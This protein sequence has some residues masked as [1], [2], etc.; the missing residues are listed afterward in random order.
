MT[1]AI[2][3]VIA[4]DW[5]DVQE[6]LFFDSWRPEPLNRYRTRYCFRGLSDKTYPLTTTLQRLGGNFCRVEQFLLRNFQKYAPPKLVEGDTL[7]HWL[8]VA[9]HHGLPTRLLDWTNSPLAALHFVTCS[10]D[11]FDKDGVVWCVNFVEA[12]DLLPEELQKCLPEARVF[13]IDEL[14]H[15]PGAMT[16]D[17][18]KRF[19]E[20]FILFFEPPSLDERIVNQYALFSVMPHAAK[21]AD[22]WLKQHPKIVR[23]VV[24]PAALKNTIRDR[25]DMLNATER[26]FFPGLDGL[27]DWLKRYYGP[28]KHK[29]PHQQ[30]PLF[31]GQHLDLFRGEKGWEYVKRTNSVQGV[32]VIPVTEQGEIILV[33]QFRIPVGKRVI[34]LPAGLVDEHERPK[35]AARREL[36]EE[37]GFE[38]D[39]DGLVP[40]C[41]ELTA[42]PGLSSETNSLWL[43]SNVTR[44]DGQLDGNIGAEEEGERIERVHVIPL[45]DAKDWL[46]SRAQDDNTIIDVKVYAGLLFS[47]KDERNATRAV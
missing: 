2:P 29:L 16:L 10:M 19:A 15:V 43:A 46:D 25:L 5:Y 11:D 7:W 28:S 34:E 22:G 39:E 27:S 31:R 1:T 13:T 6:Q 45:R 32:T 35:E 14:E 9:Q 36:R 33:E 23:R 24:I 17:D 20:D 44:R 42:L 38:C 26:V 37:T 30:P 8:S 3:E 4:K 47:Q 41:E 21:R 40:V 18:I 12:F